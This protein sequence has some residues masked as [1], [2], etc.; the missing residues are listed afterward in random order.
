MRDGRFK[1]EIQWNAP[2]LGNGAGYVVPGYS[3]ASGNFYF[4]DGE[5]WEILVKVLD[6]CALNGHYWTFASAATDVGWNLTVEDTETGETWATSNTFGQRSPAITDTTAF[7][8]C[9]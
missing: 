9:P 7:A 1:V 4:F 5:N 3:N 8:T 6:G 2:Q